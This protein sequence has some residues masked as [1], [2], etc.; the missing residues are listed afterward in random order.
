MLQPDQTVTFTHDTEPPGIV[1][2]EVDESGNGLEY[3]GRDYEWDPEIGAYKVLDSGWWHYVYLLP[4]N[5][6]VEG[7]AQ[8]PFM[9]FIPTA[10]GTHDGQ[11]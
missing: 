9:K 1:I 6:Y 5:N 2:G 4:P 3:D 8:V 11:T 10:A 7:V